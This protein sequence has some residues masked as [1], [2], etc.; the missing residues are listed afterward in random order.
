MRT[1][2]L[3]LGSWGH[4]PS[5]PPRGPRFGPV[6]RTGV[7]S[8]VPQP[9]DD[10]RFADAARGAFLG[11]A[12][13]DALGTTL[14]FRKPGT[15]EPIEDM[16]GGGP[17]RLPVGAWTDDTSMAAALA[18][19]LVV[20][21]GFDPVD[22][23]QRDVAW[24][25]DGVWSSTGE[26]FDIGTTTA[27]ALRH[28]ERS[29]E[30]DAGSTDPTSAGNGS[31]M[32]LAPVPIAYARTPARA[33]QRAANASRTTHG[34]TEAID[35][36]RAYADLLLA[37]FDGAPKE[38]ILDPARFA[39]DR[40]T[41]APLADG[42]QEVVT[43]SYRDREPPEIYGA[44]Y[45]VK[46]LEAALW[47]FASTDDFRSGALKVVNLGQDAD[48]TGAVYGQLAGAHYGASGLP[49]DWRAKLVRLD[50]LERLLNGLI[51]VADRR[52]F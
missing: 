36:C 39:P 18:D 42:I 44:G 33:R 38:A 23:M 24:F 31:L 26:C 34:A 52:P 37:A 8:D 19:S 12:I 25:R 3:R 28:F 43:G 17:F 40:W 27:K 2:P 35:A 41:D 32:R 22:Q 16:V 21:D 1:A 13:G 49:Q 7:S 14:E 10:P 46:T 51:A 6:C 30:P 29:G 50:D 20:H 15:F 5:T 48:T 45:V 47:A 9:A 11:L 4:V